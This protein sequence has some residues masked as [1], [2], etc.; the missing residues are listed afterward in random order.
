MPARCW[1]KHLDTLR[2]KLL[3]TPLF[4][5]IL[6]ANLAI[7]ALGAVVGTVVTVQ[8]VLSYP[9]DAHYELIALFAISGVAISFIVN[10]W[11]LNQRSHHWIG[12]RPPWTRCAAGN[13]RCVSNWTMSPMSALSAWSIPST[14][15]C[16]N[17]N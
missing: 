9:E 3:R 7:V 1:T 14:R 5:K 12:C 2:R 10:H 11:V 8:H 13:N 15:W 16:H 17:W 4:Y 6:L